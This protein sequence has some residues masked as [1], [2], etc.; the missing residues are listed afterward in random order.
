MTPK[1]FNIMKTNMLAQ[2]NPL[3]RSH[4]NTYFEW[5]KT[6]KP[7]EV[8]DAIEKGV[9]PQQAYRQLGANPVR[10]GI[11]AA[12]GFLKTMPKYRNQLKQ[13]ATPQLALLTLKYEN[14][15]T[16]AVI[17]KYGKKGT[18]FIEQWV[19]GALEILGV[20]PKQEEQPRQT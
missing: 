13:I 6:I 14:P 16:Y 2:Q 12:R 5:L 18:Q 15:A 11:A 10:L 7:E 19:N 8:V 17:Q 20:Q 9:T 1:L 3:V 4:I